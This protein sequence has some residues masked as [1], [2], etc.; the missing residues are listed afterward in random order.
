MVTEDDAEEFGADIIEMVDEFALLSKHL[1]STVSQ[2]ITLLHNNMFGE[3][4]VKIAKNK[5]EETCNEFKFRF[6]EKF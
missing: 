6:R 4:M 1:D 2:R 5:V 3:E